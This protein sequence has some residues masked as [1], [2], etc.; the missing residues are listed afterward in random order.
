MVNVVRKVGHVIK[1]SPEIM[2]NKYVI[3]RLQH[4]TN[5]RTISYDNKKSDKIVVS[6]TSYKK[7]FSTLSL[8]LK[9]IFKQT[10]L[11]DKIVL[12]LSKDEKLSD[13]P[14]NVQELQKFGLEIRFVDLDLK[15]H[16]KYYYAMQEFP[17][18]IVITVDDDVIY[19][20]EL[21]RELYDA[22]KK[23][24][25]CIVSARAHEITFED[26]KISNYNNWHW[27]SDKIYTPSFLFTATGVGGILYPPHLLRLNYL[28]NL[29]FIKKYIYVDD[30]W[31]KTVELISGVPTVI[32]DQKVDHKRIDIVSAQDQSLSK[33]NVVQNQNDEKLIQLE[34]DFN[35]LSK[36]KI[37]EERLKN[38]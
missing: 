15:P 12:Y 31:L 2:K 38:G 8:C 7:R 1:H 37:S 11:P 21:I 27:C 26:N 19:N 20:K 28:L 36:L 6:L 25:N 35:L 33:V 18:D 4:Q 24:P 9:S 23:F 16:K 30:L 14:Y 32:C 22:H 17:N 13:I 3:N 5:F 29:D 34:T 10:L